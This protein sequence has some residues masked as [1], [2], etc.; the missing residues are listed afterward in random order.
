MNNSEPL[1]SAS[2]L[3]SLVHPLDNTEIAELLSRSNE[4]KRQLLQK[5][6][7]CGIAFYRPHYH[8]HLYHSSSA[9]RRGLFAGNRFGKSEANS[10][11][12]VAWMLGERIW[13]K[14]FFNVLK[15]THNDNGSNRI[16]TV[17]HV[18]TGGDDHPLVRQ[19]IP[20]WPTKQLIITTN[21]SKVHSVWTSDESDRPGKLWKLLPRGFGKPSRNHEGVIDEIIGTNGSLLKF[22]SVDA[23]KRNQQSI[24]SED[25]DRIAL[26]EP[27][28]IEMWKGAARGLVDRGGV[29]D[30]TLTSLVEMWI[31]DYFNDPENKEKQ[32]R[33]SVR[34]TIYDNP[35][36]KDEDIRL[37]AEDLTEDER[38]CRLLGLPLELS[39]L[40]YKEFK[41]D[42]HILSAVPTGWRDFHLPAK[43]CLLYVRVDTHP[44]T[45]HAVLFAA[46]GPDEIPICCHEIWASLDAGALADA[47]NEY[48]K[49]T[50]C[51]LGG[52]K[53]EPAAWIQDSVTRRTAI[54]DTLISRG[55]PCRKA[56]KDVDN[57]I[58]NTRSAF[59]QNRLFFVPTLRRTIWEITRFS[60]DPD[61]GKPRDKDDHFMEDLRR[62]CIDRLPWFDPDKAA[63]FPIEDAPFENVN[64]TTDY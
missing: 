60:Y 63:G 1:E 33:F 54:A 11:E 41:R 32:T 43:H 24:E 27:A 39:G 37:F 15:V 61:T 23:F 57:G 25:W 45:P 29:G 12:T 38:T 16:V 58:L 40:V 34:A 2:P 18:H 14:N 48:V 7:E 28:P 30:F 49:L 17:D 64:L 51:F 31:Y 47:I 36:L 19:G 42:V 8:Q 22:M 6:K 44:V 10:A 3:P 26:D 50:G 46:V 55:L 21:W 56:S 9:K 53:V 4:I 35:H 5:H 20:P 13:Y 52:I 59:K 62:L